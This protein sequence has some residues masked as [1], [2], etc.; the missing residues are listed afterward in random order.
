MVEAG[1]SEQVVRGGVIDAKALRRVL[2]LCAQTQARKQEIGFGFLFV[3]SLSLP[4]SLSF[5]LGLVSDAETETP[6]RV[7]AAPP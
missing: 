4:L 6:F 7:Q 3:F 2:G 5:I 1:G